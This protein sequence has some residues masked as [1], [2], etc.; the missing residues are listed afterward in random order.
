MDIKRLL[1]DTIVELLKNNTI[2]CITVQDVLDRSGVSRA[3]FYKYYRDKMELMMSPFFQFMECNLHSSDAI[4]HVELYVRLLQFIKENQSYFENA[5]KSEGQNSCE[6]ELRRYGTS[7]FEKSYIY[8]LGKDAA[9][10]TS[11]EKYWIEFYAVGAFAV[12]KKWVENG[13]KEP[14]QMIGNLIYSCMP[15]TLRAPQ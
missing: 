2:D 12:L 14:P 11:E 1:S 15:T 9:L 4:N 10:L 5:F 13:M 3:T 7:V 8:I 6:Q